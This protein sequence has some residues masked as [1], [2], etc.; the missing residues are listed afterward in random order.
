MRIA[1]RSGEAGGTL[2]VTL[3]MCLVIGVVLAGYLGLISS[4]YKLTIR[5]QCW[6]AAIPVTEQGIEE[7]LAHLHDDSNNPAANNWT[8]GT[9]A[10][11]TVYSK[12][13]TN[14]D[15]S[16]FLANL[17]YSGT[18]DP[19]IYASG[20]IPSPLQTGSYISRT[21]KVTC[22]NPPVF[23]FAFAA[24][25]NI[26][27][28][29]NGVASD[30]FNS[31]LT[32]LSTGGQYDPLKH[33]SNGNVASVYGPVNFGNHTIDG[34]LSLGPDVTSSTVTSGQVTGQIY[35][36]FN[37]SFPDVTLPQT[38]WLTSPTKLV[39]GVLS[40]DF[41][42]SG[43]YIVSSSLPIVVEPGVTVRV[44]VTTPTFAPAGIHV[45]S[46]NGISGTL[47]VYQVSGTATL[48]GNVVIDNQRAGSFYYYGLPGVTSVTW[49]GTSTFI[50]VIYAPEAALTLN[51][52]GTS[53]NFIGA[54]VAKSITLNGH[55]DF[56]FD[57]DLLT[58]GPRR[59]YVANS[60]KEL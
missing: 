55:Y 37:V 2:A 10:G 23:G 26:Q 47:N 44:Q 39:N 56:H 42:T 48:N 8:V 50:G 53:N 6:N 59:G 45:M 19:Y 12:Q 4:R 49:G 58:H 29:G 20:F 17:Y 32:N 3:M 51:G 41:S 38:T 7:A 31:A 1:Q 16:Y 27:L 33:S 25:Y 34:S 24:I 11:Q 18:N 5:S 21:V 54:C 35:T 46:T 60:W 52:G 57:E 28:N 30:S 13:R 22:T 40:Y 14:A 43:D 36:D 9:I 15:G